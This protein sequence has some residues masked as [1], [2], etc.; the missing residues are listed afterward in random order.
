MKTNLTK[1]E[2]EQ[3][4]ILFPFD[5]LTGGYFRRKGVKKGVNADILHGIEAIEYLYAKVKESTK[6]N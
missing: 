4:D 5:Y 3:L 6:A 1:E 2:K